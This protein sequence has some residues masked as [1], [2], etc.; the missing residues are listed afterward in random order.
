MFLIFDSNIVCKNKRVRKKKR[1]S[2][3]VC[4]RAHVCVCERE[5]EKETDIDQNIS[6]SILPNYISHH[7]TPQHV[8]SR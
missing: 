4:A 3:C 7:V 2:V 6:R 8:M 1:E 5:R